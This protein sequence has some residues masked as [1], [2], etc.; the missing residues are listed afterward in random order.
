MPEPGDLTSKEKIP[1]SILGLSTE[2][3][4]GLSEA[5]L[6]ENPVAIRMILHY[7]KQITEE[8]SVLKNDNN[9]LKTYAAAYERKRS[10]SATSAIL[11][12]TSNVFI[13]FS[14]NLLTTSLALPGFIM[15]IGGIILAA[16]G[17]FFNFVK[18]KF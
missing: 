1:Q 18:D 15:L 10:D 3:L 9:T 12:I 6:T 11:L 4:A 8:N 2:E 13:G 5:D 17:I 7:Y 16:L 14:I